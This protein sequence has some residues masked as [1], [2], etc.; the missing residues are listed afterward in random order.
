MF[1]CSVQNRSLGKQRHHCRLMSNIGLLSF[2]YCLVILGTLRV[3]DPQQ[4][5]NLTPYREAGEF[6]QLDSTVV[7]DQ[8]SGSLRPHTHMAS[9][10]SD[11][12]HR[13]AV[14]HRI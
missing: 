8:C 6:G 12:I 14:V 7:L 5:S 1:D 2:Y 11:K 13:S 3:L 10:F 9:D 4:E